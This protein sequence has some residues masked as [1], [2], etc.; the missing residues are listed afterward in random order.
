MSQQFDK[1]KDTRAVAISYQAGQV[2]RVVAKGKGVV[3]EKIIQ[4]ATETGVHTVQDTAL[5]N[6]LLRT[7]IADHIPQ[8]LYTAVASVLIY[9]NQL[10]KQ[11]PPRHKG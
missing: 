8:G 2:P 1:P 9:I 6:E 7:D 11:H 10:D 4:K 5:V 3:G